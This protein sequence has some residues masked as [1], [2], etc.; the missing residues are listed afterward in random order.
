M[1]TDSS[2]HYSSSHSSRSI[3]PS[4]QTATESTPI[5]DQYFN[6]R[7]IYLW[8]KNIEAIIHLSQALN[9]KLNSDFISLEWVQHR[10]VMKNIKHT[11]EITTDLINREISLISSYVT[12]YSFNH[13]LIQA[14]GIIIFRPPKYVKTIWDTLADVVNKSHSSQQTEIIDL[15]ET[16]LPNN[17]IIPACIKEA[18]DG[19]TQIENELDLWDSRLEELWNINVK[20]PQKNLLP[21]SVY[22]DVDDDMLPYLEFTT[23]NFK[24]WNVKDPAK[25]FSYGCTCRNNCRDIEACSCI[26]HC[27]AGYPFKNG[28]LIRSDIGAIYEC[29]SFCGC[30]YTCP[31][32]NIQNN[33]MNDK[34]LQIFKTSNRGWGVRTLKPI[35]EGSFVTEHVGEIINSRTSM[36]RSICYD[37]LNMMAY[38]DL[39]YGFDSDKGSKILC[40]DSNYWCNISRFMNHS[41]DANLVTIPFFVETKD[42]RFQRI[43]F[44]AQRDISKN[45]EL[46]LDYRIQNPEF[47]CLCGSKFCR[48]KKKI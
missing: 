33:N 28:K 31:N 20:P 8:L 17:K 18:F 32:R 46:T 22:N 5:L 16:G 41:C 39:D 7:M 37:K 48:F 38:F 15:S 4:K 34:N 36:L 11:R 19:L 14:I 40:L 23:E 2:S 10:E 6:P 25:E 27:E 43:G 29:N 21:Y 42:M 9:E 1:L 44:F 35:K 30:D 45:T 13:E 26:Q 24:H 12:E 3:I 47:E